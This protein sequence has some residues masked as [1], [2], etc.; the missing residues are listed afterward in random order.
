MGLS[1]P[2]SP[3]S[4]PPGF[5]S[6]TTTWR[7]APASARAR[8]HGLFGDRSALGRI[9]ADGLVVLH[10]CAR[11]TWW[12]SAKEAEW[13]GA[14]VAT[15]VERSVG[16]AP[17]VRTGEDALR[18]VLEVAIGLDS[19]VQGEADIGRQVHE[20]LTLEEDRRDRTLNLL[21]Q[22]IE[23][24][25]ARGRS[26]GFVRANTGVGALAVEEL[27]V[28]LR[29]T[30]AVVGVVGMGEIGG[31]VVA[32]LRRGGWPE[33]VAYN[34]TRRDGAR[35][36]SELEPHD[37]WILC[38]AG[39]TGWFVPPGAPK[40]VIDLGVPAQ[41]GALPADTARVGVDEL[42]SGPARSLSPVA[43]AL[44][45]GAVD[46]TLTALVA[47]LRAP[48]NRLGRVRDVRDRF[49]AELDGHL[50]MEGLTPE[51]QVAIRKATRA[52]LRTYTHQII[53]ALGEP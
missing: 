7:D 41:A 42:V 13:V 3:P 34:R 19:F 18:H 14:L 50:P 6:V 37:V 40:V 21:A 25:R 27:A 20:A 32:A 38:T 28:R 53:R 15:Q 16:V 48:Q 4:V 2:S 46:E 51:Q 52:A 35:L 10:T 8:A 36:L 39:P 44:A 11:S 24:L 43:F 9:G 5:A 31:R 26:E 1:S 49:L 29:A 23:Q 45:S 30:T 22:S 12:A 17:V 47:R 33:P